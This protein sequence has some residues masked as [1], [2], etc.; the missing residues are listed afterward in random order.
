MWKTEEYSREAEN[1][2]ETEDEEGIEEEEEEK[3]ELEKRVLWDIVE[4]FLRATSEGPYELQH[5]S[6]LA[7]LVWAYDKKEERGVDEVYFLL[8]SQR[9]AL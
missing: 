5:F 8:A 4:D 6:K 1:E 9:D 2:E 3:H 7:L